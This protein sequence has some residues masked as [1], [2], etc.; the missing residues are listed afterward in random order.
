MIGI[1]R[2]REVGPYNRLL[3]SGSGGGGPKF[4]G[5]APTTRRQEVLLC[6][7]HRP[8]NFGSSL[9]RNDRIVVLVVVDLRNKYRRLTLHSPYSVLDKVI[10]CPIERGPS[11]R[12]V[13]R[14]LV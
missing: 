10:F 2:L 1:I 13:S 5:G 11:Y 8:R 3:A 14:L 6:C 4:V 9:Y 12:I 7:L